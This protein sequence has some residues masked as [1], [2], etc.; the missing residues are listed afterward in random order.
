MDIFKKQEIEIVRPLLITREEN[1]YIVVIMDYFFKW[2]E[3][4]TI[5]VINAKMI[6][7]FIYEEII[8]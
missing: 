4:R 8:C 5:K 6:T 7:T 1:R 3:V 2:L